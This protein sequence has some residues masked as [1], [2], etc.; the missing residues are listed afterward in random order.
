MNTP[1]TPPSGAERL[2]S[3]LAGAAGNLVECFDWFTYAAFALYFAK[4][5]FPEGDQTAQLLNSAAVYAVASSP[6]PWV[7]G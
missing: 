4:V 2:R 6:G 7:P 3:I 1:S 5:F